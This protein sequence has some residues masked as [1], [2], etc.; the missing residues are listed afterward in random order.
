MAEGCTKLQATWC[1]TL[2]PGSC[3]ARPAF[4]MASRSVKVPGGERGFADLCAHSPVSISGA[5]CEASSDHPSREV[6]G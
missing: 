1:H 5:G 2:V 3:S 4:A 6:R